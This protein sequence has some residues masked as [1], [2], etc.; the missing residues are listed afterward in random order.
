MYCPKCESGSTDC[1]DAEGGCGDVYIEHH[2]CEDCDHQWDEEYYPL[3][4]DEEEEE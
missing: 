4:E 3:G 2:V 1:F